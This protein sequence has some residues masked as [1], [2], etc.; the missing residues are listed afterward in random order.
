MFQKPNRQRG[1]KVVTLYMLQFVFHGCYLLCIREMDA[2]VDVV[3]SIRVF[4]DEPFDAWIYVHFPNDDFVH[5]IAP[6]FKIAIN[7]G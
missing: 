1:V 6:R 3:V 4:L 7:S 5:S 2:D